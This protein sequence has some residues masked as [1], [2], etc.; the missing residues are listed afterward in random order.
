MLAN[1]FEASHFLKDNLLTLHY[2]SHSQEFNREM[3]SKNFLLHLPQI[4]VMWAVIR[5]TSPST[6]FQ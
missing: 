3:L 2:E 5:G 6:P 4:I 1:Y